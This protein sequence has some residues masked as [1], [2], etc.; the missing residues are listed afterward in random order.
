MRPSQSISHDSRV[1][2]LIL[3]GYTTLTTVVV[4]RGYGKHTAAIVEQGGMDRLEQ[5]LLLNYINFALGIM[6][7]SI[8]KLAIAALLNRILNPGRFHQ[9][10]MWALTGT[11]FVTSSICIIVLFTMCDPPQALW[12]TQ[13][14]SH[15]ATCR[16]QVVLVDYA[17]FTGD[18]TADLVIWTSIESN[19][20]IMASCIP[21]LGPLYEMVRGRRSWSSYQRYYKGH[22]IELATSRN[23]R[24]RK[25]MNYMLT[26]DELLTTNIGTL[27]NGSEDNILPNG[28]VQNRDCAMGQIH[29]T[30][31]VVVEYEKA[32]PKTQK[33]KPA[34]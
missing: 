15:G 31:K 21:T 14:L 16:P 24:F 28:Q 2:Q 30:D 23:R 12:K 11:V 29:R 18:A 3:A 13:L 8:P 34:V 6:S 27:E 4:A 33:K 26:H 1:C 19:V 25:P 9:V 17:I 22:A 10:F 32:C 5:V 20:I 7:F